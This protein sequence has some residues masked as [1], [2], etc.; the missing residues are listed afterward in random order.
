MQD[1]FYDTLVQEGLVACAKIRGAF[2][3]LQFDVDAS[4]KTVAE[5]QGA[6]DKHQLELENL[7]YEQTYLTDEI[8]RCLQ[9]E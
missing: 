9:F 5:E 1:D 7:L 4:N 2:R 8:K 3:D 6:V